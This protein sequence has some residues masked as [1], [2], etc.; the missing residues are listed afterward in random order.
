MT[1]NDRRARMI[2][3]RAQCRVAGKPVIDTGRP[4]IGC[5]P[6]TDPVNIQRRVEFE[7]KLRNLPARQQLGV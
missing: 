7:M 4:L 5:R 3:Y 6:P 2:E 1:A